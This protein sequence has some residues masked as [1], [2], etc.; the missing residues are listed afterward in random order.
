MFYLFK[1]K[2][3]VCVRTYVSKLVSLF[4]ISLNNFFHNI[5]RRS[6]DQKTEYIAVDFFGTFGVLLKL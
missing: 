3:T 4:F 5:K 2:V 1:R 6:L